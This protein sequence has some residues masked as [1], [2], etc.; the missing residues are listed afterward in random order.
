MGFGLH[1]LLGLRSAAPCN[2]MCTPW[3]QELCQVY[4][5]IALENLT[6]ED[7]TEAANVHEKAD[8]F[9]ACDPVI[10]MTLDVKSVHFESEGH[11]H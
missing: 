4:S 5:W 11:Q 2:R 1:L 10:T 6:E 7:G 3:C 9:I 8:W